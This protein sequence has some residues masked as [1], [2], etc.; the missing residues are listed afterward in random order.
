MR[1]VAC[2]RVCC[3]LR[4][5]DLPCVDASGHERVLRAAQATVTGVLP[6][7]DLERLMKPFSPRAAD[8]SRRRFVQGIALGGA[9]AGLGL[10]RPANA[11]ALTSPGQATVLGGTEFALDIAGAPVDFTGTSRTATTVN[12]SVPGPLLHWKEGSTVVV[13]VTNRLRVPTS[14][15]WHGIILPA[16]MDGVPGLSFRRHRARRDLRLPLPGAAS[17]AR[18]GTTRIRA[19]RSRPGCTARS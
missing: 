11:W 19:F 1:R 7:A 12:G 16:D 10:L 3:D 4:R 8:L 15:H 5:S 2:I 6:D 18:T 14:I 13:R 9:A 17:R